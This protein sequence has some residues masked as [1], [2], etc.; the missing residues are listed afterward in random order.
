V[1]TKAVLQLEALC[2]IRRCK[3]PSAIAGASN[4]DILYISF[5][6]GKSVNV[7][8]TVVDRVL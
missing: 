2:I 5:S 1:H 4:G 6:Q 8:Y 7:E 3:L